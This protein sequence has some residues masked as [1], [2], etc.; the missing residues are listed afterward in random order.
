MFK[1]CKYR[2]LLAFM[3]EQ[4]F[5][6]DKKEKGSVDSCWLGSAVYFLLVLCWELVL[7]GVPRGT[8]SRRNRT[9]FP[10]LP[11][12]FH[13][14]VLTLMASL[15]SIISTC[16]VAHVVL[17]FFLFFFFFSIFYKNVNVISSI[18]YPRKK[19]KTKTNKDYQKSKWINFIHL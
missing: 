15:L 19:G 3:V 17:F 14:P 9:T 4:F 8:L 18:Y 1:S 11:F 13:F 5:E 7:I 2:I 16:L 6:K 10:S 12:T